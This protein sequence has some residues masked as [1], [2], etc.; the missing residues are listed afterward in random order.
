[1]NELKTISDELKKVRMGSNSSKMRALISD[2]YRLMEEIEMEYLDQQKVTEV[3]VIADS[4]VTHL[5]LVREYEKYEKAQKVKKG[6]LDKTPSDTYYIFFGKAGMYQ[7]FLGKEFEKKFENTT[8]IL[9]ASV[10][11]MV[12]FIYM[13]ILWLT[14]SSLYQHFILQETVFFFAFIDFGLMG[15]ILT[16]INKL[17]RK[18]MTQILSLFAAGV[19]LYIVARYLLISNFAF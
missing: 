18:S 12:L 3:T 7:K 19:V 5:D 8:D 14:L 10:P 13:C 4:V 16:I 9:Y 1:M 6:K 2:S 15:I 11:Y 17:K